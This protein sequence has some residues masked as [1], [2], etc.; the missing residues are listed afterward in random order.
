MII[1]TSQHH[2]NFQLLKVVKPS[3]C[4]HYLVLQHYGLI[5]ETAEKLHVL[6]AVLIPLEKPQ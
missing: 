4:F 3:S 1:T 6:Y 2:Y 5:M